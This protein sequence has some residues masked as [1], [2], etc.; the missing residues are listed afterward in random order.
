MTSIR[1]KIVRYDEAK[2][3]ELLSDPGIIRNRLKV[4]SIIK[5]AR[6]YLDLRE[7]GIGFSDFLWSFVGDKPIQNHWRAFSEVPT[8][9][10]RI[11]GHVESSEAIRFS[12]LSAQPLCTPSCRRPAW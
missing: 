4:R 1:K 12:P 3:E 2:V 5:N 11:R 8:H 6:G 9:N 7:Q 10:R